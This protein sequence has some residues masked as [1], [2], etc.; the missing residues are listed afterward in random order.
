MTK[1]STIRILIG[2]GLLSSVALLI[3]NIRFADVSPVPGLTDSNRVSPLI[4][5]KNEMEPRLAFKPPQRDSTADLEGSS[6]T[7]EEKNTVGDALMRVEDCFRAI[8]RR[9]A[10]V[11]FEKSNETYSMLIMRVRAPDGK[12][13][14]DMMDI[15][16]RQVP[17]YLKSRSAENAYRDAVAN[18]YRSYT[19]Y[20]PDRPYKILLLTVYDETASF[21]GTVF[22]QAFARDE[23]SMLPDER[24]A[25]TF[26]EESRPS[27]D[28]DWRKPDSWAR[29]RYGYLL[30]VADAEK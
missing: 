30:Q 11:A 18:V 4:S 17:G 14:A 5:L 20:P 1:S 27:A 12:D 22:R 25:L 8:E 13:V 10:I 19:N 29:K 28:P 23:N 15:M 3:Y 9:N 7:S 16:S 2:L 21:D 24:G 26:E 6:L